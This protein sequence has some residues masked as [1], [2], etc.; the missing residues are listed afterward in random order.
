MTFKPFLI[1]VIVDALII[2]STLFASTGLR[3]SIADFWPIEISQELYIR[4]SILAVLPVF[5]IGVTGVYTVYGISPVDRFKKK[6]ISC[7]IGFV[8]VGLVDFLTSSDDWS[9]GTY[10]IAALLN[11]ISLPF[12]T[13]F[14]IRL[15][16]HIGIWGKPVAVC[17]EKK[18]VKE[19]VDRLH[20]N[21]E[22]GFQP[23]F[24]IY[25]D[26]RKPET[27]KEIV[28]AQEKVDTVILC[29]GGHND[30]NL[31]KEIDKLVF[32]HVIVAPSLDG[33]SPLW[34]RPLDLGEKFAIEIKK[35][36]LRKEKLY[37]K[38]ILDLFIALLSTPFII[39]II[40]TVG[41]MI[42]V[43]SPGPIF[44]SQERR[45]YKGQKIK[46][47]KLRSMVMDAEER[48]YD[49]LEKN[50][51]EK[52]EWNN[53]FKLLNDP[54][55][56]PFAGNFIRKYSI[57]ELPQI[58]NVLKGE[59]SLVGPRPLPDYHLNK[60]DTEFNILRTKVHTGLTGL[61]Q[62]SVRSDGN[63]QQLMELDS[64]Y[65][66]NWSIWLDLY[67]LVQTISVVLIP[68]GAR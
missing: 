19:I 9:R 34:A 33:F 67:I 36:L 55:I 56:I 48:L 61:W 39:P 46:V 21:D 20:D 37:I 13:V 3:L 49:Y 24:M 6:G 25:G 8:F 16:T 45:G 58:L 64:Y 40:A 38:R 41:V 2:Q 66:R 57:D 47:L 5:F 17:G 15:M 18:R 11:L 14:V 44:Y 43:L 65:I 51:N 28:K 29:V 30:Y 12:I 7:A 54:R 10:V 68:K 31:D 23:K 53:H 63:Q 52:E 22:I 59:M 32:R 26:L 27:Q 4:M 35:G 62:I 60:L 1:A 50:P 42:K